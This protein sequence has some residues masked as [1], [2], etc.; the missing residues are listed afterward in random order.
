MLKAKKTKKISE[1]A[2]YESISKQI[3]NHSKSGVS[4]DITI[5][6]DRYTISFDELRT[7]LEKKGYEIIRD[8]N[9]ITISWSKE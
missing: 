4:Y 5:A 9:H 1:R 2:A 6:L 3:K 8:G 7:K